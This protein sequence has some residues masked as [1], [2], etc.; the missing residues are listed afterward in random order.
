MLR[1]ITSL[2][3]LAELLEPILVEAA[4]GL[5]AVFDALAIQFEGFVKIIEVGI[6]VLTKFE[7]ATK[8]G[9]LGFL[10]D[11]FDLF[12]NK[13]EK[14]LKGLKKTAVGIE[15]MVAQG[16]ESLDELEKEFREV[17]E[18]I[19]LV[20]TAIVDF[21]K[22][23][24]DSLETALGDTF[25]NALTGRFE[26]FKDTLKQLGEDI[27]RDFTRLA[28]KITIRSLFGDFSDADSFSKL[29]EIFKG[30]LLGRLLGGGGATGGREESAGGGGGGGIDIP[31]DGGAGTNFLTQEQLENQTL[32]NE[33]V[34]STAENFQLLQEAKDQTIAGFDGL[35]AAMAGVTGAV[36]EAVESGVPG[37]T[38]IS[39]KVLQSVDIF[40]K[41]MEASVK[42]TVKANDAM[43]M[44]GKSVAD[45]F[46]KFV[47]GQLVA[48]AATLGTIAATTVAVVVA[49]AAMTAA[50]TPAAVAAAIASFGAA[51]AFGPAAI[52]MIAGSS[53]AVGAATSANVGGINLGGI[54]ALIGAFT[55][56]GGELP[57]GAGITFADNIPKL[58]EGGIVRRPTIGLVG[59]AGPEAVVPLDEEGGGAGGIGQTVIVNITEPT[60]LDDEVDKDNFVRR[61]SEA[62]IRD[63]QRRTGGT[64]IVMSR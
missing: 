40:R 5:G 47:V 4:K 52:A 22:S 53:G 26:N 45:M 7:E 18:E 32:L 48:L 60:F 9:P 8:I 24:Q 2:T 46:K 31:S 58:Q 1:V 54:S 20:E 23:A 16:S 37:I 11:S 33:Q 64:Q 57:A 29:S 61:L 27:L 55:G 3:R 30:S 17:E 44:L 19:G 63:T 13:N 42:A 25:F 49:G 14:L 34:A 56:G 12:G 10:I 15:E 38:P 62:F 41:L 43:V 28:A 39:E 51:L 59:E 50:L 36:T 6:S 21:A 35:N